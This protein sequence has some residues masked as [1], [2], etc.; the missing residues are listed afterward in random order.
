MEYL[1][2][3]HGTFNSLVM[4]LFFRQGWL[5]WQIRQSRLAGTPLVPAIK[6]HRRAGPI[7]AAL[8]VGGFL[9]GMTLALIDHGHIFHYPYHF[10]NGVTLL[11]CIGATFLVSRRLQGPAPPWRTVH[12]VLGCVI[13][14]LY[15]VQVLL[16]LG[17]LL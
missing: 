5:G 7:A 2:L 4:L 10:L 9:V 17:I 15:P 16:G 14:V 13:L 3:A 8:G 1:Q 12:T 11:L 6:R